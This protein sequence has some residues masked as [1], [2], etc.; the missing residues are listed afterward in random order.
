MKYVGFPWPPV[1]VSYE[2]NSLARALITGT[3]AA[4]S[5]RS[6]WLQK[7][8]LYT[9]DAL[10]SI[11]SRHTI[12]TVQKTISD[13]NVFAVTV[14]KTKGQTFKRA[15][16]YLTSPASYP[17]GQFGGFFSEAVYLTSLLQLLTSSDM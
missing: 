6:Y 8:Y 17:G 5:I 2:R 1:V 4:Y 14:S 13:Q 7:K 10:L 16:K 3:G 15:A 9:H 12:Q 11:R